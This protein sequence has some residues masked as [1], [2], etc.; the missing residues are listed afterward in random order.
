M[1]FA[2]SRIPIFLVPVDDPLADVLLPVAV[3]VDDHRAIVVVV[4]CGGR[5]FARFKICE[6]RSIALYYG[7]GDVLAEIDVRQFVKTRQDQHVNIEI[8][9]LSGDVFG[10]N[11]CQQG[12]RPEYVRT[13]LELG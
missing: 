10:Q 5:P 2:D 7:S 6:A 12:P 3:E 4:A 8:Y 9:Y 11:F 13:L 1:V